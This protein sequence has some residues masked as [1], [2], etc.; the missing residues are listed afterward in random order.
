[1]SDALTEFPLPHDATD[2]ERTTA[3]TE[4]G[5]YTRVVG[6]DR[7][8]VRFAGAT[9]GQTGPIWRFQY[10]RMYQLPR[11]YLVVGH[12]LREG[13]KVGYADSAEGLPRCFEHEGVREFIEDE[14]RFRDVI[15][16]EHARAG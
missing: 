8:R 4:I 5:K 16:T 10:L 11:G 6:D 15:A 1:M 12:E 7:D 3:R 13:I 14:L 2:D 9:I